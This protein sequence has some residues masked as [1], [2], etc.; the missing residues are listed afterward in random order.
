MKKENY[1]SLA[2]IHHCIPFYFNQKHHF[3]S[4]HIIRLEISSTDTDAK[5]RMRRNAFLLGK[6]I[7]SVNCCAW[8][9]QLHAQENKFGTWTVH[10][11]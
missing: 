9:Q 5:K 10:T 4:P 6:F 3:T 7:V 11:Q 1:R 8:P 2:M